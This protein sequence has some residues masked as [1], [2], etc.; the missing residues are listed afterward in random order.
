MSERH[1]SGSVQADA[2][3][4]IAGLV[5]TVY[6]AALDATRWPALVKGMAALVGAPASTLWMHDYA[7][8]SASFD[9]G[10]GNVSAFIGYD[11]SAMAAYARHYSALNVWASHTDTLPS[12]WVRTSSAVYPD[13]LLRRSEF[14]TDWL[15][16]QD[17][18]YGL[19]CAIERQETRAFTLG[20]VRSER[21]GA[22]GVPE[23]RLVRQLMPHLQT[24]VAL[25]RKLHRLEALT[26]GAMAALDAMRL[27]VILLTRAGTLLHANR[28]ARAMATRTAALQF[29]PSGTLRAAQPAVS[30]QLQGLVQAAVL[31][32]AGI[33]RSAGGA[34][35]LPGRDGKRLQ[36]VVAPLP[37]SALPFGQNVPALVFC[38]DPDA[39]IGGLVAALQK[40]YG[41]TA[42][43]ALLTEAL[44]N[45]R[46]LKEFAQSRRTTLNTVRTQL[47][48]AA[49]KAGASRQVDLV[50][51]V[52]TGPA[53]WKQ[54]SPEGFG[55][56]SG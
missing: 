30:Q 34:L 38:S 2:E 27:G 29:G 23:L 31:T 1:R 36:V 10:S 16:P 7:D 40:F 56:S 9:S 14:L 20:F 52:L 33:G 42:A 6:E 25:H 50:R 43:E 4:R 39:V 5:G 32:G 17:L 47:R 26:A 55:E 13:H 37:A 44:V 24:A 18:F 21:A 46:S 8:G 15:G 48:A 22:F 53:V 51:Q 19:G 12:G 11:E 28:A 49:A 3:G 45:G 35:R 41:M 54:A